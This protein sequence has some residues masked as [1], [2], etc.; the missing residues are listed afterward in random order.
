LNNKR[1]LLLSLLVAG[2]LLMSACVGAGGRGA[3]WPGLAADAQF[4]Y[5]ADG[6]QVYGVRLSDGSEAWHY[7]ESP[8]A[9]KL[10]YAAPL[11]LADGRVLAGS[12]GKDNC[13]HMIDPAVP[14][15]ETKTASGVCFFAEATDHWVAAPLLIEETL[16][17]PNNDGFLYAVDLTD[18]SLLWSLELGG[19]LWATPV[20]DGTKIYVTSLN[21]FVYAV[22]LESHAIAWSADLGGS[23]PGSPALSADGG[24][25]FVGSFASKIFALDA[26]RGA[27]L[28]Q[29][30]ITDWAWG[31]PAV[32]ED[33]VYVAD[34]QGNIYALAA[35]SGS[36]L[37][38]IKP[39]EAVTGRPL[40]T[41]E[42]VAVATES[43]SV[44]VLNAE[45]GN[46][47]VGNIEG[48][49]YTA[50]VQAGDLILAA[51]LP[52]GVESFLSAFNDGR[53]VWS[54]QPEN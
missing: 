45:G 53:L 42:G 4:A 46:V 3:T 44:I 36:I 18:G 7:P 43:G 12:A 35:D 41:D 16:Y 49:V 27:I 38:T 20:S 1:L 32:G 10:F 33:A 48:K 31:G 19:H 24:T 11:A 28:W 5:L 8:D 13:I 26:Q 54:F 17:A 52:A 50:P 37:W 34:L 14:D 2:A 21:H 22:D 40:V 23:I 25:L 29:Q 15:P 6:A 47:W 30:E 39:D 51:P 9:N